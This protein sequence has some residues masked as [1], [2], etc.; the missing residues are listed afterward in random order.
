[1]YFLAQGQLSCADQCENLHSGTYWCW[2]YL[3]PFRDA[4]NLEFWPSE[5]QISRKWLS[6]GR[7]YQLDGSFL[8]IYVRC[9]S[10]QESSP[11]YGGLV[12]S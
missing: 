11:P 1:M 10:P 2:T 12:Y 8:K 3:V 5:Y 9:G 4:Q 6:H 7:R